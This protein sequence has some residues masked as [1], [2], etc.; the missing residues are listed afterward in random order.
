M[1]L[2]KG[3]PGFSRAAAALLLAIAIAPAARA[4]EGAA[5]KTEIHGYV[6]LSF[7]D[8]RG[9]GW[10]G[11]ETTLRPRAKLDITHAPYDDIIL[12]FAGEWVAQTHR[13]S[14]AHGNLY[15]REGNPEDLYIH[16]R[17]FSGLPFDVRLGM[18]KVPY[19][20]FNTMAVDDRNRPLILAR[21][22]E[23][24]MGLRLDAPLPF[25]DFSLAMVNGDGRQ[26][27]DANSSKSVA[28]R[29]AFPASDGDIYPETEEVS[30]YPNP[31][32]ANPA[33]EFRWLFAVSG[34]VGDRYTTPIKRKYSHYGAEAQ[35]AYSAFSLKMQYTFFEGGYNDPS[36]NNLTPAEWQQ[37]VSDLHLDSSVQQ[38][39]Y[40][41]P[42]GQSVW[43]ELSYGAT[44]RSMVTLMAE[45]YDPDMQSDATVFQKTKSRYVI[46]ARHDYRKGVTAAIFY[47]V[48]DNPA[49]GDPAADVTQSDYWKGDEVLMITVAVQF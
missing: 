29:A 1:T 6:E 11:S 24:D 37:I 13:F 20:F 18:V 47:T 49:F 44:E 5:A 19:G 32:M 23:W 2:S 38:N 45:T 36:M 7:F 28:V 21:S 10:T 35:A 43:A 16:F 26:G 3:R 4:E 17:R 42:R 12:R 40:A 27:T 33:G 25:M 30:S 48:N 31:R 15:Q 39:F 46:G 41:Y 9:I 34:Y 22:R 8:D 14:R